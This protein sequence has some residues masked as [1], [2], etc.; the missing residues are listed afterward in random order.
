MITNKNVVVLHTEIYQKESVEDFQKEKQSG[1]IYLKCPSTKKEISFKWK[2]KRE[3]KE[4][5]KIHMEIIN[6][7]KLRMVS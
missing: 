5:R 6:E 3:L 7:Y 4:I 2:G 1:V